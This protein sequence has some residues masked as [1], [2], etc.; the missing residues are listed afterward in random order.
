MGVLSFYFYS[1]GCINVK[2]EIIIEVNIYCY[3]IL[4]NKKNIIIVYRKL[5]WIVK[6]WKLIMRLLI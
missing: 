6:L 3:V 5:K 1:I 4:G 2:I